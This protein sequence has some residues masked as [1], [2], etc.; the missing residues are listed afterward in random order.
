MKVLKFGGSSVAKPDRI[1][2][3][4]NIL[5]DYYAAGDHFTVVFSAFGGVT[6]GLIEMSRLAAAGDDRYGAAFQEFADRHQDAIAELL[7][8]GSMLR[9]ETSAQLRKSHEVLKNL[10]YGIFLVREASSRTMD[11]VLSFGE[12]SSSYII[13]QA[14]QHAGIP[15]EYLDARKI[16]KTDRNFGNAKVN[17]EKT[18][19]AIRAYYAEHPKVQVVTGFIAAAKGGLTTTLGRGGSDYTA[20]LVGA[21]LQADA[22]EIWTDVSGVL[23][24]DPRR[25]K[26]AFTIPKMTYAEAMEMSHFGAKVIYPPTLMP[27][28]RQRIPLYIKN[29]FDPSFPGTKV[30]EENNPDG[31]A[32]RGISSINN[33]ALLTLSGS[34]LFGVPGISA[35]LF[36][37][38]AQQAVN[39]I[40]ITQGSS[41]HSISFAVKPEDADL[42]KEAVTTSFEYEIERGVV[43]PVKVERDLSVVAI[44]GEN[45]RYQPGI[46]GRLFQALGK[47]GINAVAI[48]QGSSE[49]NVSVV[50]PR[51]DENKALNALHEAFFLSDYK[52][53][54]LFIVGVGLI[55][56]T[57]L[58]QINEQNAYLRK[59]LGMEVKVV[60]LANT[61]KMLFEPDG[62]DLDNWKEALQTSE[63]NVDLA[64]F[65]GR[66]RDLNLSNSIFVDNTANDK[67]A[68]YYE[69]ILDESISISTPNKVA[70]SSSYAQYQRLQNVAN[71]R[72]VQFHYETNVG[73]GLP[74]IST[75]HDLLDS[76]D[77]IRKIEGVLSGSLSYIFN[78]FDGSRP[79]H[80]VVMDAKEKGFTEPDPRID[81]S[82]K[83]V[84]R[85]ILILARET[86]VAMEAEHVQLVGF[87]PPGAMEAASVDD[88]FGVLE[89]NAD[90]FTKLLAD[91]ASAGKVLRMIATLEGDQASVGIQ[92]VGPES[93]F[94]LLSGSDNMIVFTTDRYSERPLVIR[95]PGAGAEVTAAGVF[96]EI[97]KIGKFLS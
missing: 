16:I 42:A 39:I 2:G 19:T 62:I 32:V 25:V 69:G 72:G 68:T 63:T 24:A 88:F 60:G 95:G 87:L 78:N 96:A 58:K 37:A 79:Y 93:P 82:G 21:G 4:I 44:I 36:G 23:T 57:L 40:L 81:L 10:L 8:E 67:I 41:E 26:K 85:K 47:N 64:V 89:A 18:Y 5:K 83:D 49:L 29:T 45:M 11:Y 22:I 74:V 53:L 70:T 48:A 71:K 17:F 6:D 86:G 56:G 38:L 14:L 73:A 9:L 33:V 75:L 51:E 43:N 31:V 92:A 50:I 46:S 13:A 30:S 77:R 52:S 54:H 61:R 80:E 15:A 20:S 55:G 1:R 94:F 97:I 27:A 66:M 65:V 35:R 84:G 7:P 28:L 34:G 59:K 12:R 76:G 3:I 90:Y 91:A